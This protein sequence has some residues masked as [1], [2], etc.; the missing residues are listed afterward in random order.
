ML[1]TL[2]LDYERT[3]FLCIVLF[4]LLVAATEIN[5]GWFEAENEFIMRILDSSLNHQ[6]KVT[7]RLINDTGRNNT[8][9]LWALA[10][11]ACATSLLVGILEATMTLLAT[12]SLEIW[13]C[14]PASA[15]RMNVSWS[16]LAP[17]SEFGA[18]FM[19]DLILCVH[20]SGEGG[21]ER[22]FGTWH[23]RQILLPMKIQT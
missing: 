22:C 13:S 23:G 15:T 10:A 8:P 14:Y 19:M 17:I 12:A 11:A 21:W 4:W 5:S 6:K 16:T 2:E 7:T 9:N 1:T 3:V 18:P 20:S